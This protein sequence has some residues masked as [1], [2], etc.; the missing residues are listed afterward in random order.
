[1]INKT[2]NDTNKIFYCCRFL[3][4][5][6]ELILI[7]IFSVFANGVKRSQKENLN[8]NRL[9]RHF[10]PRNDAVYFEVSIQASILFSNNASGIHPVSKI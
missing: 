3:I 10:T 7:F 2:K 5:D 8:S 1:M 4:V 6:I 9:L